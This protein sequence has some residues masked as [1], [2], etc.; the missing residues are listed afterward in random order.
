MNNIETKLPKVLGHAKCWR[1][2]DVAVVRAPAS[3]PCFPGSTP[4]G[5]YIWLEIDGG[6]RLFPR[7]YSPDTPVFL[8]PQKT[9]I[10]D[11]TRIEDH[12]YCNWFTIYWLIYRFIYHFCFIIDLLNCKLWSKQW[13]SKCDFLY[14]HTSCCSF[15]YVDNC[16][17]FVL[18]Y[19]LH[20]FLTCP[21]GV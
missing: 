7:S 19:H 5:C 15:V 20:F 12:Q 11:S 9:N 4:A 2:R 16:I 3:H 21:R 10:S 18:V 14:N 17:L 1:S 6:S 8:P 13:A